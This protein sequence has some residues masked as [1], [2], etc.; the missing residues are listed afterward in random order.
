[1]L[2]HGG[3]AGEQHGGI[4]GAQHNGIVGAQHAAPLRVPQPVPIPFGRII[5]NVGWDS[6]VAAWWNCRRAA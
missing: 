6:S 1:M 5:A 2:Q 3:I 4:V